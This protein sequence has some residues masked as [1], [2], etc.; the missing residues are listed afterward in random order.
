MDALAEM[1]DLK[2]REWNPE[3]ADRV[4]QRVAEVI[5]LADHDLIDLMRSRA[6]EQEVLDLLDEPRAR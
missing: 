3:T 2:L 1:L 5:E 6:N 4:R